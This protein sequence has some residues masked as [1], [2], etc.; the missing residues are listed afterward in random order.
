VGDRTTSQVPGALSVRVISL[1]GMSRRSMWLARRT[2]PP[3]LS[4]SDSSIAT[5]RD[6]LSIG[7]NHEKRF[8]SPYLVQYGTHGLVRFDDDNDSSHP[9]I[10]GGLQVC[11]DLLGKSLRKQGLQEHSIADRVWVHRTDS[12]AH[13]HSSHT[14]ASKCSTTGGKSRRL[15]PR[16]SIMSVRQ[17]FR[18]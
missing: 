3:V 10:G 14:T 4:A 8:V 18:A 13:P 12:G 6:G 17:H 7:V 16:S 9:P 15:T 1:T 11:A 5:H 2:E